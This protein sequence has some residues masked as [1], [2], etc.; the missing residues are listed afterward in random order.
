MLQYIK[1]EEY[2]PP[3][4]IMQYFTE[5]W[6]LEQPKLIVTVQGNKSKFGPQHKI[7]EVLHRSLS[8]IAGDTGVWIFTGGI[9][10]GVL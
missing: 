8:T 4:R 2:T 3:D 10:K 1:V 5:E 6:H 7:K 9:N